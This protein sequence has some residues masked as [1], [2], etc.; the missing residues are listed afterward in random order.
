MPAK[1]YSCRVCEEEF[2]REE[3]AAEAP[4]GNN[5]D[6]CPTCGVNLHKFEPTDGLGRTPR[7]AERVSTALRTRRGVYW[8]LGI[9]SV[10]IASAVLLWFFLGRQPASSSGGVTVG[11]PNTTPHPSKKPS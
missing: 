4:K 7:F 10:T 9:V 6:T 5:Y 8:L 1:L 2:Q 11:P 3:L